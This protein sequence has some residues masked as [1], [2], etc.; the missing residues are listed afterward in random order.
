MYS[1]T[2]QGLNTC[3]K[4]SRNG[5]RKK[6]QQKTRSSAGKSASAELQLLGLRPSMTTTTEALLEVASSACGNPKF[7]SMDRMTAC[8]SRRLSVDMWCKKSCTGSTAFDKAAAHQ[9]FSQH[10][11]VATVA[12]QWSHTR[13]WF[14]IFFFKCS[15][16][17]GGNDPI[18]LIFFQMGWFNHQLVEDL[19]II[20]SYHIISKLDLPGRLQVFKHSFFLPPPHPTCL[21]VRLKHWSPRGCWTEIDEWKKIRS[22]PFFDKNGC[23]LKWG[24]PKWMVYNGKPY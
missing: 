3:D 23:F 6:K 5:G 4:E 21:A 8:W 19:Y 14:Q 20:S 16:L 17:F 18:W 24:I 11:A 13:W 12:H 9:W 10:C 1:K 22:L 7:W 15:S 2:S